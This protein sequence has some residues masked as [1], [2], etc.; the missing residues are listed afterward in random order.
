MSLSALPEWLGLQPNLGCVGGS[1]MDGP[2][3]TACKSLSLLAFSFD[4]ELKRAL[5][6]HRYYPFFKQFSQMI[7]NTDSEEKLQY[8]LNMS[9]NILT[10]LLVTH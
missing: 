10:A 3:R 1:E 4:T 7:E 9:L 6:F 8:V 5:K 2:D